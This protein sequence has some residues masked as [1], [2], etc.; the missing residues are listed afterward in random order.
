MKQKP[1]VDETS[2]VF[3]QGGLSYLNIPARDIRASAAFYTGVFGWR[4]RGDPDRGSFEDGGGQVIGHFMTD[5]AVA[6]D[7]GI[8]P[9]VYVEGLDETVG[10]VAAHGG[11]V[12]KPIYPEGDV[13]VALFRDPAGNLVGAWQRP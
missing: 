2:G 7:A 12:V 9:Y 5:Q 1:R 11:T 4:M 13:R 10:R 6:G 8:V 3:R